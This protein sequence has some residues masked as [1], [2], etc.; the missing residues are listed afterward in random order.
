MYSAHLMK[1]ARKHRKTKREG[2]NKINDN[3]FQF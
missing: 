3:R 1:I 2:S